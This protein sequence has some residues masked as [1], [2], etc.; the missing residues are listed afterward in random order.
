MAKKIKRTIYDLMAWELLSSG[1]LVV[2]I[3]DAKRKVITIDFCNIINFDQRDIIDGYIYMIVPFSHWIAGFNVN[4]NVMCKTFED[5]K[6]YYRKGG[7]LH[8]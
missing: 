3:Q 5:I 2:I 8:W 7:V 1:D 6:D 4:H